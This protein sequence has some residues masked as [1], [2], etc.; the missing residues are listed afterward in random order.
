MF[1]NTEGETHQLLSKETKIQS[2]HKRKYNSSSRKYGKYNEDV[3]E[4]IWTSFS[5]PLE[6]INKKTCTVDVEFIVNEKAYAKK[7][8]IGTNLRKG[9][10][11]IVSYMMN[12]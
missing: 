11:N 4:S 9:S 7:W 8:K 1:K 2:F 5:L 3:F 12:Y 10:E 6:F